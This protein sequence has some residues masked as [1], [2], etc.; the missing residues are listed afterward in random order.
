VSLPRRPEDLGYVKLWTV[1]LAGLALISKSNSKKRYLSDNEKA[2]E[3]SVGWLAKSTCGTPK[4]TEGWVEL[5]QHFR[6]RTHPDASNL[7]KS[8]L[9]A[10]VKAQVFKD[11]KHVGI[12]V[13]PFPVYGD[14]NTL[15]HIWGKTKAYLPVDTVIL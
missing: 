1:S 15:M 3:E 7:P 8:L 10:L 5:E 11:D 13:P 2:F 14:T 4:L 6:T 12:T 9:D